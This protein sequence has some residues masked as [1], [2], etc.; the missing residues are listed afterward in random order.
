[1]TYEK[2]QMMIFHNKDA[3]KSHFHCFPKMQARSSGMVKVEGCVYQEVF[4]KQL[5]IIKVNYKQWLL[6][7]HGALKYSTKGS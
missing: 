7:Q 2:T 5:L 1:M 6:L 3:K 4:K